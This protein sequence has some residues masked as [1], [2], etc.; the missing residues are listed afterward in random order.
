LFQIELD[1]FNGFGFIINHQ[2]FRSHRVLRYHAGSV[3]ATPAM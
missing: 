2:D 3:A 1:Q